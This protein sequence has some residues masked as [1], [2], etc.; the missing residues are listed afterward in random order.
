MASIRT[1]PRPAWSDRLSFFA[2]GVLLRDIG[3]A[4]VVVRDHL[5]QFPCEP[6]RVASVEQRLE[7]P[8]MTHKPF[9]F[10]GR[11]AHRPLDLRM[12]RRLDTLPPLEQLP[13]AL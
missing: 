12:R 10:Q 8:H 1:L 9:P 11:Q 2:A 7:F 6:L 4:P 13:Q 5:L 3:Q